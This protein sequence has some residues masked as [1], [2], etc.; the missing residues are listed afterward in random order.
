MYVKFSQQLLNWYDDNGRDL[1]WRVKNY[2]GRQN[3][4]P[5][6]YHVWLSEIMLQ[7]TVVATV[8]DYYAKFTQKWPNVQALATAQQDEVLTAWAGLGYYARARNLHKCAQYICSEFGGNFPNSE[9]ILLTLPG[10]GP[11]TAAAIAAIAFDLNAN[12]VDG[13][14]ERIFSRVEKLEDEL[15]A[16]KAKIYKIAKKYLPTARYGDY[17]QALMDLGTAICRPKNPKCDICPIA[18]F[19]VLAG[20]ENVQNYPK[21]TPKKPKKQL[22]TNVFWVKNAKNDQVLLQKRPEKGLLG[23]MMEFPSS[24]WLPQKPAEVQAKNL[25]LITHI[26]THIKLEM[27]VW[28]M[29]EPEFETLVNGGF[30]VN[31]SADKQWVKPNELDGFALPSLMQKVRKLAET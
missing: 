1:P 24:P 9:T 17:A 27:Q 4:A 12:V 21:K 11:Y 7:Q 18:E 22:K 28:E 13:N 8:K 14:I 29:A 23:N 16:A 15:P 25:G 3:I 5:D 10:V 26:F 31:L 30:E 19:C 6:P 20:A 2:A